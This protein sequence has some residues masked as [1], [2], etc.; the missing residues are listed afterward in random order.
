MHGLTPLRLSP[1]VTPMACLRFSSVTTS[2]ITSRP[3]LSFQG[4]QA[5][6]WSLRFGSPRL[7]RFCLLH[8]RFSNRSCRLRSSSPPVSPVFSSFVSSV[9]WFFGPSLHRHYAASSLLRPLLTSPALSSGDLPGK[10][11]NLSPRAARLYLMRLD[12]LWASLFPASLPPAPGL[13]ASSCSYGRE[14]ATRFFQLRL[15]A[16][17]CVSL[18]LPSS[19][20]VGSFHPMRF[21]PC[22][23]HW[24][25]MASCAA[26]D[27]A[28]PRRNY[29]SLPPAYPPSAL[30]DLR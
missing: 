4:P 29:V 9:P 16:T 8:L 11:Q 24:G 28:P 19:A 22:W 15:A 12:D 1:L 7:H 26:V 6:A 30:N 2:S 18:R 25:R 27:S 5:P 17:P 23:A 10:V 13:T 21:C 20:P 14:F 3:S